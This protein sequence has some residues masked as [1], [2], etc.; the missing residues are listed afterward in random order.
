[1]QIRHAMQKICGRN[2]RRD[3]KEV[4]IRDKEKV[5]L[6]VMEIGSG[7]DAVSSIQYPASSIQH[8]LSTIQYPISSIQCDGDML[9]V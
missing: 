2:T 7:C 4:E 5:F 1:M 9:R 6:V 3:N 8:P